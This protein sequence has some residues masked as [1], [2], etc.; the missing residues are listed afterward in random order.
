MSN[1]PRRPAVEPEVTEEEKTIILERL[2]TFEED[3]KSAVDADEALAKIRRTLK[4]PG[5]SVVQ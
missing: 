5:N 2:A 1:M 3:R 4:S